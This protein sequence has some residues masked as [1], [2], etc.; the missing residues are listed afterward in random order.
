MTTRMKNMAIIL[1]ATAALSTPAL[2]FDK[3]D[4]LMGGYDAGPS[5]AGLIGVNNIFEKVPV[6][7]EISLGYSWVSDK[8]DP[9]LARK[10]FIDQNTGGD[11]D[12][13]ST[14]GVLDLT[15]NAVYPLNQSY[16]T[17]KFF[18]FGGPR[19]A[20]YDMRYEYV[21]GDE[22]FDTVAN[23]WGLGGGVRGVMPLGKGMS[24]IIQLGLDYYPE[25]SIY[26]HDATYYPDNSNINAR[27]DGHGYT[28]TYD[29]ALN[30]TRVPH[31]RPRVMAGIQF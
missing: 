21:G 10:V 23:N 6:G 1:S 24:A 16:G 11:N 25:G 28:Y 19:Y 8:G 5:V 9:I 2:A 26:G 15:M 17:M 3:Y 18:V 31:I 12:A 4:I 20:H 27:N 7:V 22:D 13:Q 29:D 14:G 30:A